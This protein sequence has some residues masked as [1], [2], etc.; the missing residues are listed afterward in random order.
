MFLLLPLGRVEEAIRQ[1]RIAEGIDPLSPQTHRLLWVALRSAGRFDEALFHCQKA[2]ANDRQR[3]GCW[4]EN[5]E[6]QGR[7]DEAVRILEAT[8]R[9]HLMEPGAQVLGV[10]YARAGRRGDASRL[11]AILPRL[12]SKAQVFA[13]LEDKD[14]TLELLDQMAD[15]GPARIG[16]DFLIAPNFAFLRGDP[17]VIALRKNIGLPD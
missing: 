4:A 12:A 10:A 16:R 11:A 9:D 8:W 5:L 13:A 17:R 3:S 2:A 15:M 14:R 6:Q 7:S 1:L